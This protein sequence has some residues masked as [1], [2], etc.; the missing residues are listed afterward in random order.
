MPDLT[1]LKFDPSHYISV[2]FSRVWFSHL[3]VAVCFLW[4]VSD[5]EQEPIFSP[6]LT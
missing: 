6:R 4:K 2:S 5:V 3:Q 1:Q